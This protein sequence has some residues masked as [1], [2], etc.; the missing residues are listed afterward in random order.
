MVG[1]RGDLLINDQGELAGPFNAFVHAPDVG[2]RLASLGKVLR[3]DTSLE[4]RLT[5]VA[6]LTVGARWKA[7]F[8]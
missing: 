6:I 5:E 2:Q 4:R 8:E 1:S 3:F 7:E